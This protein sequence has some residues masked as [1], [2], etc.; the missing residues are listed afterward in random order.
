MDLNI[1]EN[2]KSIKD[3]VLNLNQKSVKD[4]RNICK[5]YNIHIS[6][7]IKKKI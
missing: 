7:K 2:S 1:L 5:Q 6:K 4:L 3:L